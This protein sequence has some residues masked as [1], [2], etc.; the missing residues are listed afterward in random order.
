MRTA[1][2]DLDGTLADTSGDMLAA[3]N[4]TLEDF[5]HGTPLSV[6]RHAATA[7]AGGR[8]MLKKGAELAG[9]EW[10]PDALDAAYLRFLEVYSSHLDRLSF[11]YP[12]VVPALERLKAAGWCLCVCTNKPE[13]L[14]E[15]L[16]VSLN[17]RHHFGAMIGADTLP[18]RKPDPLPL[19]EAAK[20]A[21]GNLD[22]AVMI[23][24]TVTDREAARR[25]GVPCVLVT[26]GPVGMGVEDLR[27][28]A[29][30]HGFDDVE[31]VLASVVEPAR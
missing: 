9:F 19:R 26:F 22:R 30:L 11:L 16:L 21:G 13:A 6:E 1:I 28:E 29:L 25:A 2:F 3:A 10:A 14:A 17:V 31:Q 4:L 5:G 23:G 18:V 12:G 20:R 27:P 24:D 8:A 7:F 15:R